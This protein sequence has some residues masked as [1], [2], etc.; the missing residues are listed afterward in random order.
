MYI[1]KHE[2]LEQAMWVPHHLQNILAIPIM[3]FAMT[4]VTEVKRVHSG[5]KMLLQ[6]IKLLMAEGTIS[7][8]PP[9]GVRTD[10][11]ILH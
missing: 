6:M 1:I 8:H 7:I 11:F 4:F 2:E 9:S 5:V 10:L 3:P